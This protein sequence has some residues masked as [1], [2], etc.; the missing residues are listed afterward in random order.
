MTF[1]T[2]PVYGYRMNPVDAIKAVLT[3]AVCR[4]ERLRFTSATVAEPAGGS[5]VKVG[6]V[7]RCDR[8]RRVWTGDV[9]AGLSKACLK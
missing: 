4:H 2:V 5:N 9:V 1:V 6:L 3:R 7:A 8:C